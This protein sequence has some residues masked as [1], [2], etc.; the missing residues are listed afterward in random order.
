MD[1][2]SVKPDDMNT[3]ENDE[4]AV[5]AALS[6]QFA[7]QHQ[8]ARTLIARTPTAL[9]YQAVYDDQSAPL[10]VGESVLRGAAVLERTFGGITANLWDD[11]FEWTLPENLSTGELTIEYLG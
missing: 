10:S 5:I 2:T 3:R 1:H 6:H 9:L 4:R 11:P 7:T 8:R